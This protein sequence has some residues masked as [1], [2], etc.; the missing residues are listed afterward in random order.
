MKAK[1]FKH[2]VLALCVAL[3]AP[4]TVCAQGMAEFQGMGQKSD[5]STDPRNR[6]KIHTELGAL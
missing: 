6:A 3:L 4:A 1:A 2:L 5:K